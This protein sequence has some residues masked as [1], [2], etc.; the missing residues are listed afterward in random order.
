MGFSRPRPAGRQGVLGGL[1]ASLHD[2]VTVVGF[3]GTAL[4]RVA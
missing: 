4:A 3:E 1:R 2:G